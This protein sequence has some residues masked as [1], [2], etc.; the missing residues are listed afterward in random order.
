MKHVVIGLMSLGL[1]ACAT[2]PEVDEATKNGTIETTY[3]Q[4]V[5]MESIPRPTTAR[6]DENSEAQLESRGRGLQ[7][8][9]D[10]L[11]Q[12]PFE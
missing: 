11:S 5:P 4:L 7:R 9:A 6:L 3:P 2:F 1:A 8:R 10:A 12:E